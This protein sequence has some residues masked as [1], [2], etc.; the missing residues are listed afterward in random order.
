MALSLTILSL[1]LLLSRCLSSISGEN[2]EQFTFAKCEP[3]REKCRD[4]YFALVKSLLGRADNVFNL[5]NAFSPPGK[6]EPE[7]VIVT[8]R[9]DNYTLTEEKNW[10]W[11]K[12]VAYYLFS[13]NT[14]Q[15]LSLF[16]SKG[17]QLAWH[18][19]SWH[20]PLHR[21]TWHPRPDDN[22]RYQQHVRVTLNA[23]ECW[24]VNN[25]YMT[26]LTQKVSHCG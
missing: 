12:S 23:T 13:M 11:S 21:S 24:G 5:T 15:V 7:Y 1:A 14:F 4:C 2:Q 8:Y 17:N 6:S 9:F 18:S 16:L 22:Q 26:L 3:N 25:D 10:F 19:P 20:S